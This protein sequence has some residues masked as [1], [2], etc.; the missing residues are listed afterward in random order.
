[1][2]LAVLD[3]ESVLRYSVELAS[4]E[5]VDSVVVLYG[6]CGMADASSYLAHNLYTVDGEVLALDV[7]LVGTDIC[8]HLCCKLNLEHCL[9]GREVCAVEN[10]VPLG[11]VGAELY[12]CVAISGVVYAQEVAFLCTSLCKERAGYF[13][14]WGPVA[15]C[16]RSVE[17]S[18][19]NGFLGRLWSFRC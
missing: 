2:L 18:G 1:M 17:Q 19:Y 4:V 5:R 3:I 14:C 9:S 7:E 12:L 11:A 16:G 10:V 6:C 13:Y 15:Y 8:N